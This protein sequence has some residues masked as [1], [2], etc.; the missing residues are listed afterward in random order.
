MGPHKNLLIWQKSMDLVKIVYQ[1]TLQYP[2]SEIYGLVSQMRRCAISIP[3]NIAEGCGRGSNS[4]LIRFLYYALGSSNELDTQIIISKDLLFINDNEATKLE[5][6]NNEVMVM[7]RSL[8]Q[9]RKN[10]DSS[11]P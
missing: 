11:M 9:M 6:K 7:L 8:I 2:Q 5:N 3:S 4:E 1:V 10:Q